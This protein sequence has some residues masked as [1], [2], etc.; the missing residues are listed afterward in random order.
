VLS[1]D[2][3]RAESA[4]EPDG[5][6]VATELSTGI[7]APLSRG[8]AAPPRAGG[9]TDFFIRMAG[10]T[11]MAIISKIAQMVRR[12]MAQFTALG[13]RIETTGMKWMAAGKT[14]GC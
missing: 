14:P 3:A 5:A 11:A 2:T 13:N 10:A 6:L 9:A 12:S 8:A 1:R 4:A 7:T